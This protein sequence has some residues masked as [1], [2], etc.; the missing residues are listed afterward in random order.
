MAQ[1]GVQT[2]VWM[3][4]GVAVPGCPVHHG[5]G[6]GRQPVLWGRLR[7]GRGA[8]PGWSCPDWLPDMR[9]EGSGALSSEVDGGRN[10]ATGHQPG[11]CLQSAP[12]SGWSRT[13]S[14]TTRF[15]PPP[16]CVMAWAPSGAGST[17]RWVLGGAPLLA[18]RAAPPAKPPAARQAGAVEDD[19]YDGAWCAE[20]DAQNQWIEVDTRRTTRFTGVITQGRDS[21]VQY[22]AHRHSGGGEPQ[23]HLSST[24]DTPVGPPGLSPLLGHA[25]GTGATPDARQHY[26]PL[27]T[28][29]CLGPGEGHQPGPRPETSLAL[30]ADHCRSPVTTL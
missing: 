8:Q 29:K 14:R 27:P 18:G 5:P 22:V 20:D 21:S 6:A 19:Y 30:T 3:R 10:G 2:P 13:A 25:A 17:C 16:C 26:T 24:P 28:L 1:A 7:P 23:A 11:V 4:P 12:P 9:R 15:E